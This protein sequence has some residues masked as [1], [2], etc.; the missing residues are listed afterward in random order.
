MSG[1]WPGD[2]S[3]REWGGPFSARKVWL[4]VGLVAGI[5]SLWPPLRPWIR[6][7]GTWRQIQASGV[8]RIAID[9]GN[10]PF[11]EDTG[12]GL[13][14]WDITL[15]QQLAGLWGVKVQWVVVGF[16][17]LYDALRAG[18]ADMILSSLPYD[19]LHTEEV[20]FSH[21]YFQAGQRLLVPAASPVNGLRDLQGKSVAVEWGSAADA[22]LRR[23]RQGKGFEIQRF[24][25]PAEA[26]VAVLEGKADGAAVDGVTALLISQDGK[27]RIV[28]EAI[29]DEPYVIAVGREDDRLLLEVN[30][31]LDRVLPQWQKRTA[32]TCCIQ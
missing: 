23:I 9:P 3:R 8:I 28:K 22:G 14:G 18:Q 32:D 1:L 21:P 5:L 6:P 2:Q 31:A 30:R 12:S 4:A 17:G 15:G 27:L 13:Q 16:D 11:S 25:S 20:A 29:T 26:V 10:P 19:A 24:M 7:D